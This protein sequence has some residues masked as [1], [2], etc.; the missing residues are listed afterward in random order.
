MVYLLLVANKLICSCNFSPAIT[1]V[2]NL[3]QKGI[4]EDFNFQS[5]YY[6][7]PHFLDSKENSDYGKNRVLRELLDA[8]CDKRMTYAGL[9]YTDHDVRLSDEELSLIPG[10]EVVKSVDALKLEVTVRTGTA[11]D[12]HPDQVKLWRSQGGN[13]ASEFEKLVSKHD[14]VYKNMLAN[15]IK[16]GAQSQAQPGTQIVPVA[17]EAD[18]V[19]PAP[20]DQVALQDFESLGA[21]KQTDEIK[22]KAASEVADIELLKG[23]SG[24]TYLMASKK[25][26]DIPRHTIIGGFGTGKFFGV[27]NFSKS[28]LIPSFFHTDEYINLTKYNHMIYVNLMIYIT[29]IYI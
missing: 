1:Q 9:K 10:S 11:I 4:V 28:F 21:L 23:K 8:W 24:S 7:S 3:R 22:L 13:Y 14:Q 12:I 2:F 29:C 16:T 19:D 5:V 17:D 18:Q 20:A 15:V 27:T 26:R 6:M 25:N